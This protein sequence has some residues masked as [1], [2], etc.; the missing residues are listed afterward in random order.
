[1]I[2]AH[3]DLRGEE[4]MR[5]NE[6]PLRRVNPGG[7]VVWVARWTDEDGR[8]H[9]SA[10]TFPV[11]GPCRKPAD[12]GRCCAQ[13]R[14]WRMYEADEGREAVEVTVRSYF[15]DA[16]LQRHPRA[17]RTEEGYQGRVRA[18]LGVKT[19]DGL[20]GDL[21]MLSV[22]PRHMDELVDVM[23][24]EHGRA[25]SGTRAVLAV[26]SSMFKDAM[27]DEV[28]TMN[29]AVL[30]TV[31]DSDPRVQKPKRGVKVATREEMHAFARA[32]GEY[33]TLVRV[34][35]D[36]GLRLGEALA[37][38]ARHDL[39]DFMVVEQSGWHGSV[40]PGTKQ[41]ATRSVPI[42]PGLR[43][44]LD[45]YA[46]PLRGAL[47]PNPAGGWWHERSF[48][49]VVW[50]PAR[51]RSGMDFRPHDFRHSHVSLMRAA[52]VDPADLARMSGHTVDTATRVYTH[53]T[54]GSFDL[55]RR[56]VG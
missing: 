3:K 9:P 8:R 32:A 43:A 27:R 6:K 17:Q 26:L 20:F 18:V 50:Y 54:G 14:I 51:D 16:W 22:R 28:A 42:P 53:S 38:E 19:R 40:T 31:R 30:T 12:D 29:P 39:R 5:R 35:A 56:A 11:K 41:G 49:R 23:L 24:R 37:L 34:I 55:V 10:G 1:M 52:G 45:A 7:A 36:L 21:P 25:V 47:F 46:T 33:E 15:E 13:H 44:L 48:Y 4:V 2:G